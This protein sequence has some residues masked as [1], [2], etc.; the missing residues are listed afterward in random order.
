MGQP[1][2][3]LPPPTAGRRPFWGSAL[4]E[5]CDGKF[6][7]ARAQTHNNQPHFMRSISVFSFPSSSCVDQSQPPVSNR[8]PFLI[9]AKRQ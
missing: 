1:T 8:N 9:S 7:L 4:A 5:G 6:F 2:L 3:P